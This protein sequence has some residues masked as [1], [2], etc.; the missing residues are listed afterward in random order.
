M[1]A[2]CYIRRA[3]RSLLI[4]MGI[5]LL[6]MVGSAAAVTISTSSTLGGTF[7]NA[8]NIDANADG[9][10]AGMSSYEAE[11][12][13]LGNSTGTSIAEWVLADPTDAC[14]G[15]S[16]VIN[17]E[18][19]MGYGRDTITAPN[20]DQLYTYVLTATSCAD[21]A[22]GFVS[23]ATS[24]VYG[25][26]GQF[27]EATGDIQATIT[28]LWQIYD[29]VSM[30]GFGSYTGTATGTLDLPN[31]NAGDGDGAGDGDSD[32]DAGSTGLDCNDDGIVNGLDLLG[33]GCDS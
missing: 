13:T 3:A 16:A 17:A 5:V 11:E 6:G 7:D 27:A 8:N 19:E 25:G 21:E 10:N 22:G 2:F 33:I 1:K 20:G 29:S 15:G 4:S 30:Q 18:E 24:Q 14:P 9:I 32:D 28:G 31:F 26:T 23:E 12:A